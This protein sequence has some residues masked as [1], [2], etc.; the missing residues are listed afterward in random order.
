MISLLAL[1]LSLSLSP[2]LPLSFSLSPSLFFLF[3]D[4]LFVLPSSSL[5]AD[6]SGSFFISPH[7]LYSFLLLAN[8]TSVAYCIS[9]YLQENKDYDKIRTWYIK[10]SY[11][12]MNLCIHYFFFAALSTVQSIAASSP[13]FSMSHS[14]ALRKWPFPK[15]PLLAESGEGWADL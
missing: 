9:S 11:K 14:F 6:R 15:N 3:F 7:F 13:Y 8:D 12:R 10:Q 5:T 4:F 2:F 1:C